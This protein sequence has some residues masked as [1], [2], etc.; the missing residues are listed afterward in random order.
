MCQS[1]LARQQFITSDPNVR[2][3]QLRAK[4]TRVLAA[5]IL[6]SQA[7]K[8]ERPQRSRRDVTGI[9]RRPNY[10]YD[11]F[12]EAAMIELTKEQAIAME[13]QKAPLHV[14]NPLTEEVYVLIRQHVYNLTCGIVSVP[15]RNGWDEDEDEDL[16]RKDV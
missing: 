10:R 7:V 9:D 14:L 1:T 11:F 6:G 8:G 5:N 15:N 12:R 16:I 13:A 3:G 2:R 4:G